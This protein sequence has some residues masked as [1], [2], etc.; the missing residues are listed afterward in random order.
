M[1]F[2]TTVFMLR[3]TEEEL[4][5]SWFWEQITFFKGWYETICDFLGV[6]DCFAKWISAESLGYLG[7]LGAFKEI[8]GD[9]IFAFFGVDAGSA[10][11]HCTFWSSYIRKYWKFKMREI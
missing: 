11:A 8:R 7:E 10:V 1:E 5:G 2:Y 4:N 9:G 6:F 3:G